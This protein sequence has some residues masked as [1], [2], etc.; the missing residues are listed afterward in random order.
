MDGKFLSQE[1]KKKIVKIG[2]ELIVLNA[3]GEM[4]DGIALTFL[5]N[6][7]DELGDKYIHDSY[8]TQI[9]YVMT[10]ALNEE[11]DEASKELATLLDAIIDIPYLNDEAEKM[12]FV[13]GFQFIVSL[14]K[15]Y[16]E[17]KKK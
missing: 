12:A 9:N 8:D 15:M 4:V 11:F 17:K 16:I 5:V 2:D 13:T 3:V 10:L 1:T 14:V 6:Y 7:L